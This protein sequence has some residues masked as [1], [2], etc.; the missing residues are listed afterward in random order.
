MKI[1]NSKC[2]S[3]RISVGWRTA[4]ITLN[5]LREAHYHEKQSVFIMFDA[6]CR[7]TNSFV[8]SFVLRFQSSHSFDAIVSL[9]LTLYLRHPF[10]LSIS[11]ALL[12]VLFLFICSFSLNFPLLHSP[13]ELLRLTSSVF[14]LFRPTFFQAL[15]WS[16]KYELKKR[17]T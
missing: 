8:R 4:K 10:G 2:F 15:L 7:A 3:E 11:L 6:T 1:A 5:W 16:K 9:S 14:F 13:W 12:F 17:L